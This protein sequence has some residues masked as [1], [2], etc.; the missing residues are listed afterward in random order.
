[1]DFTDYSTTDLPESVQGLAPFPLFTLLILT[2]Q[3]SHKI[4]HGSVPGLRKTISSLN[5][6]LF[7]TARIVPV[8]GLRPGPLV[9]PT[10]LT[11][12]GIIINITSSRPT[13]ILKNRIILFSLLI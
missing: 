4:S 12:I 10:N 8:L 1:M 9:G 3:E 2:R 13:L 11:S 7:P 5:P 6:H